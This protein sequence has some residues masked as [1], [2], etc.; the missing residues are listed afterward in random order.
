MSYE[1]SSS[2][3]SGH[4]PVLTS[5]L[6]DM[7]A[8][9]ANQVAVD[10][11][12][13]LGGHARAIEAT[14]APWK[15]RVSLV[16][17]NFSE[18]PLVLSDLKITGVDML[19]ADIGVSSMQLDTAERGFSLQQDGPLDMRMDVS[20]P[21]RAADLVNSLKEPELSDLLFK[22]GEESKSRKI[23]KLICQVRR[24]HRIDSTVELASIVCHALDIDPN[25]VGQRIHPATRTFQALRIAVNGELENLEMLLQS[26]PSV[27]SAGGR[28]AV[29]SFHSLEDRLVKEDF[30]KRSDEG[31][32][33][34]LTPKPIEAEPSEILKNSR[35]RSA[36]LRVVEKI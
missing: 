6:I 35:S 10:C 32:Y 8:P 13:G 16:H 7:L 28:F 1:E 36:K 12:V 29:I 34:I 23:T 22:Y 19:Y 25:N 2:A 27:L 18:L 26:A 14:L 24:S 4:I 33:R 17:A 5:P 31:V 3:G 20:R 30:K 21:K 11:T 9:A 15:D